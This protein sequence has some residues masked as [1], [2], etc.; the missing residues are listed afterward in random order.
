MI[1]TKFKPGQKVYYGKAS[2]T[3]KYGIVVTPLPVDQH[4]HDSETR[5]YANWGAYH[6]YGWM[7]ESAVFLVNCDQHDY[8]PIE[9]CGFTYQICRKCQHQKES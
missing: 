3:K 2:G 7:Q 1:S 4:R 8:V 6:E 9:A 5:V